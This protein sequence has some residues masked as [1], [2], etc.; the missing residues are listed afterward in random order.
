MDGEA[1][2]F[3]KKD[4]GTIDEDGNFKFKNLMTD[5]LGVKMVYKI[6]KKRAGN[7]LDGQIW[8]QMPMV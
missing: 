1:L 3:N 7:L 4:Y 2:L 8:Q 5:K 6:G